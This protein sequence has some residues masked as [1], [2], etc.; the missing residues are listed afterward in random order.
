MIDIVC[1][2]RLVRAT[3]WLVLIVSV[4]FTTPVVAQVEVSP[5]LQSDEP[6]KAKPP[7][8]QVIEISA[9]SQPDPMLRYRF[10]PAPEKRRSENP[11]VL[12][13]RAVLLVANRTEEAKQQFADKYEQ[14]KDMPL[15]ELPK[16]EMHSWLG[17][18]AS[19]LGELSRAELLMTIDYDLQLD[20]LTAN[21]MIQ[22]LLPEFQEMRQL[23][24][25][26]QLRARL[27]VAEQRWDD[28]V[29]DLRV[30]FRLAEVAAHSTD[31]LIG[32]LVGF[33]IGGV[34][35]EVIEEAIQ[36]PD[37]PNLYW[38]LSA[39]PT[40]RLFE[41]KSSLEFESVLMARLFDAGE[42]LP[43]EPI[44]A[45]AAR[46]KLK[47][48]VKEV[49]DTLVSA[50]VGAGNG[51]PGQLLAGAYV[52]AMTEP[53]RELLSETEQWSGR[54]D[55]LSSAEAVL[56]ATLLKFARVRDRWVAWSTLPDELWDEYEVERRAAFGVDRSE[57]DVLIQL[58]SMLMPA[59]EA[60]RTAG[61]RGEQ[62]HHLLT[63][64]EAI[65]MH[66][67]ESG[68]LPKSLDKLRPVPAWQDAIAA[69]P[70]S[71]QRHSQ[72]SATISRAARYPN[73]QETTFYL[74]LRGDQ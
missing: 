16:E 71:Y 55:E 17:N 41:T 12:V 58:A 28:A 67:A 38:A 9:R 10:W 60:A 44:G 50:Q 63:T 52:V 14:W 69:E 45:T 24:R 47:R 15:D 35:M 57:Q 3:T 65:R 27:A 33:A 70:F 48:M 23:A 64:I 34:M 46:E 42:P 26:L 19:A 36:Q 61:L 6:V 1:C 72:D 13:N 40:D 56:R 39:M 18:Y 2:T 32:R 31:F 37:C 73:D 49:N 51:A 4:L 8:P 5:S 21:E 54:M 30:G 11:S 7:E 66:A 62:Q 25:L 53:C 68:E 29:Q 20:R 59:V 74:K 43:D 22:T